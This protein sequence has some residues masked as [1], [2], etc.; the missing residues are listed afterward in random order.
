VDT[1]Q[2]IVDNSSQGKSVEGLDSGFIKS[3]GI[4]SATF[5]EKSVRPSPCLGYGHTFQFE[6]KVIC[7]SP[8][9]M[10]AS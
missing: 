9:F 8:T 7:K 4:F 2:G 10:V 3:V 1:E 5:M 6:G